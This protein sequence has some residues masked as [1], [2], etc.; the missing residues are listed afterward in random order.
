M[1]TLIAPIQDIH[2]A[3]IEPLILFDKA[4]RCLLPDDVSFYIE[5]ARLQAQRSLSARLFFTLRQ[6][7]HTLVFLEADDPVYFSTFDRCRCIEMAMQALLDGAKKGLDVHIEGQISGRPK[8]MLMTSNMLR[9]YC[10]ETNYNSGVSNSLQ[11]MSGYHDRH[12][13]VQQTA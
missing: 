11:M 2:Y 12:F 10:P 4:R 9:L 13:S 7:G 5:D 6:H 8:A 3:L 1:T